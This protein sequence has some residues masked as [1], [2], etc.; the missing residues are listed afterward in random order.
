MGNARG[1]GSVALAEE[2]EGGESRSSCFEYAG[3]RAFRWKYADDQNNFQ[4]KQTQ[5]NDWKW[6]AP[7]GCEGRCRWRSLPPRLQRARARWNVTS[8]LHFVLLCVLFVHRARFVRPPRRFSRHEVWDPP[9]RAN[10][11]KKHSRF[12]PL[13][14][15]TLKH[16]RSKARK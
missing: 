10:N 12:G 11:T 13:H 15:D 7:P 14:S 8:V 9:F 16:P 4:H 3:E 2:C 1:R 5:S 6:T